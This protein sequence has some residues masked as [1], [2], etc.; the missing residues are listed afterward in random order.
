MERRSLKTPD[1]ELCLAS[2]G[3]RAEIVMQS[4]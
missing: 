2:H 1:G 4:T 3:V